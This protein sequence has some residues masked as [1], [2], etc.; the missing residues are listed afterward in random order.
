MSKRRLVGAV[1]FSAEEW[2]AHLAADDELR[3]RIVQLERRLSELE[4]R[5]PPPPSWVKPS[6]SKLD[7]V[8]PLKRGAREGH[9]AHHRAPPPR[10]DD[11]QDVEL[12]TCPHCGEDLGGPFAVDERTVEAIVPGHVRVT[13]Y[14][15]GR[16]RCRRCRKVRRARLPS[17]V[18]PP[19]SHFDWGT[20]FLVGYWSARGQTNSM[21]RDHLSNDY[22]LSV[23]SGS[24][25]TMLRRAAEL[26]A[27]AYAAI[28]EAVR[29][30]GSVNADWTG[31]RVDGVNHHLWDFLSPDARAAYF[32]VERS[33]GHTVPERVLGK[34]QKDRVL[35]C[36]GGTAFNALSGRK[37]R[38]WVHLLRHALKGLE[39]WERP[40]DTPDYRGLR[41]LEKIARGVLHAA[42][43]EDGGT[44]R[45][46]ARR[47]KLHLRRWLRVE[48]DGT[49]A[50]ALQKFLT[51]RWDELWWWAEV[52]VAAHNNLAEQ[53]LRPHIAVKRKLSWGSRTLGGAARTAA[54]ASVAQTGRMQGISLKELGTRVLHG[55]LN[56]F[57]FGP[58][59]PEDR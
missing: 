21:V 56:P 49:E 42:K 47:L 9:E 22:G 17:T 23:S 25:D 34:R 2:R 45:R 24:V 19:K 30:G 15:I 50:L 26:F 14:R 8:P 40:S 51:K 16:Y 12:T 29:Q 48:R 28:R 13:K 32:T 18:A 4:R 10:I 58:G 41:A 5:S 20:H 46:E 35:I 6:V 59:P 1:V 36:D 55:Q 3:R 39:G 37:Q 31:W 33:A 38:C 52:G 54:L 44:K 57:Q 11:V 7:D 53:G 27:P 43:L